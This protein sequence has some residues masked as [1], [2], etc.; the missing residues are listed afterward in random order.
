MRSGHL[1]VLGA[2][3]PGVEQC[4]SL[5]GDGW[6]RAESRSD[7]GQHAWTR[8][9]V[10][11]VTLPGI[12]PADG[13]FVLKGYGLADG[14]EPRTLTLVINGHELAPQPL[15]RRPMQISFEVAAAQ[16]H[17]GD[18]ELQLRTERTISP[19]TAGRSTDKRQLGVLVDFIRFVPGTGTGKVD[20][21]FEGDDAA[22]LDADKRLQFPL[23]HAA[24]ATLDIEWI[25]SN[26][27]PDDVVRLDLRTLA[28]GEPV[29]QSEFPAQKG[30]ARLELPGEL[31]MPSTL[32]MSLVG[33]G[34]SRA[35]GSVPPPRIRLT[36]RLAAHNVVLIVIDTQRADFLGCYGDD[37]GLTPHID[38]LA[39]DGI[40]F[41]NTW[42][43]SPITGPSHTSLFTSRY[44]SDTGIVNNSR[45]EVPAAVPMLAEI[46]RERG[47]YTGA[48]V[49]IGPV[50]SSY[51]FDRGFDRY[52]DDM[53]LSWIVNADIIFPRSLDILDGLVSPF[54]HWTHYSDPHEPYDA[55]GLVERSA[56]VRVADQVVAEIST[57][58]YTPTSL[59]L[60]LEPGKTTKVT[61]ESEHP[62]FVRK[63]SLRAPGP[64]VPSLQPAESSTGRAARH[65]F[66]IGADGSRQVDLV[67]SLADWIGDHDTL[68]ERYAREVAFADGYVG[69]LLDTLRAR[70]LY[71][72]SLI[73]VTGDHGEALGDHGY[74]GH[75]HTLYE[76]MNRVPLV[77]KPPQGSGF[78][79]GS[80]RQDAAALVDVLPT[81][82]ACL[83]IP[84]L[85]GARGRDLLA[86]DAANVPALVFLETHPPEAKHLLFGLTDGRFKII[87][88][89]RG[90]GWELYDLAA[91]PGE[92]DSLYREGE[93][94]SEAWR[95]LL[96]ERLAALGDDLRDPADQSP[97]DAR[98]REML[99]SLGY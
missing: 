43:Q 17:L 79:P 4:R 42:C 61:L 88:A 10:A 38:R 33:A 66:E 82:L 35:Q 46:L 3:D 85:P 26:V 71:D 34:D 86:K 57:S 9:P 92:V 80:R 94:L 47:Y 19:A 11:T 93:E 27:G 99:K 96:T 72:D 24:G 91:D 7:G 1:Q 39:D 2:V 78:E 6:G 64:V 20:D 97:I 87:H 63:A 48:V 54:F 28:H 65:A 81:V 44:P 12:R 59:A 29:L 23:Y 53:G 76:A 73:I 84:E 74:T 37:R 75:V 41:E 83:G 90:D 14:Q 98:T 15:P 45:G 89:P 70:D 18:N 32:T 95:K 50:H 58:T 21:P 13:R 62:F 8:Q 51:G 36:R 55:H 49:S 40:V 22:E 30:E 25:T 67:L 56:T 31:A 77:V 52:E 16:L 60:D 69:A 68:L 5:L